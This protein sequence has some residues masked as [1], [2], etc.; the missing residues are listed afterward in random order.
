MITKKELKEELEE[1]QEK[2]LKLALAYSDLLTK[3]Q[4]LRESVLRLR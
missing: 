2:Y 3:Y 4:E 1:T